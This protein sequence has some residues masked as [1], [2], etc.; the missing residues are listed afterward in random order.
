MINFNKNKV[1]LI[2]FFICFL[3]IS[4]LC[5]FFI[6]GNYL[7]AKDQLKEIPQELSLSAKLRLK[8]RNFLLYSKLNQL[9][10]VIID[11][12]NK[13]INQELENRVISFLSS[14]K[15]AQ[16]ITDNTKR[17]IIEDIGYK[18]D[19]VYLNLSG[20][21]YQLNVFQQFFIIESLLKLF[22]DID[23]VEEIQFL[24][25]TQKL[26]LSPYLDILAPIKIR[27]S[28]AKIAI[29]IDDFGNNA[30]GTGGILNLK[31]KMTC[32]IMPFKESSTEEAEI[33]KN[34]G[35]EVIIHL[36]METELDR[37]NWL[38]VKPILTSLPDEE[39]KARMQEAVNDLPQAIGFNNHTGDKASADKRVMK[40]IL[41]VAKQNNLIAIDSRT[42][43]KTVVRV[44]AEELG[45]RV[46]ERDVFLDHH[47]NYGY[48][49]KSIL[50]LAGK[51]IIKGQAIGIGHVGPHGGNVTSLA[52][53]NLLPAIEKADIK[54]VT[55]SELI[56]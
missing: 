32:A 36:P 44:V 34:L 47:K 26:K 49:R 2:F 27:K 38:G 55:V 56:D 5:T 40:A 37:P 15:L 43:P 53:K 10:E 29:I 14:E 48:I 12:E 35:F 33:A 25:D 16:V 52:L 54:F 45:V 41:E 20:N 46:L 6:K 24:I 28:D 4:S 31:Q 50:K 11:Q 39:I 21:I 19:K 22:A 13:Q 8:V 51:S 7:L 42:T 18:G 9:V 17:K 1:Y 3:G 23:K 30:E